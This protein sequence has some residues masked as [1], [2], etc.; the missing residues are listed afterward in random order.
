MKTKNKAHTLVEIMV[1]LV[2]ISIVGFFLFGGPIFGSDGPD[3][4]RV[5]SAQGYKEIKITGYKW[6]NGTKDFYNTGFVATA[7]NGAKVSG[8]VSKGLLFKGSTV[9]LD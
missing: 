3:A 2:A 1:V 9:R 7:P 4:T 6:F 8:N 5:L